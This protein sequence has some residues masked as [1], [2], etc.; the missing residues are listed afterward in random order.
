MSR[1]AGGDL[2]GGIAWG[3]AGFAASLVLGVVLEPFRD[4][5]VGEHVV[6]AFLAVVIVTAAAGGRAAGVLSALSAALAYN[7]FFTTPYRTL[8]IDSAEQVVT[9][10]LL[11]AA[12]LL[13]SAGG[14]VARRA[15]RNERLAAGALDLL[16]EV[17][18]AV[19]D[20]PGPGA[21]RVAA[22]GVRA[23]LG[24]RRVEV[25]RGEEVTASA[26]EAGER[27]DEDRLPRMEP[28][29]RLPDVR[30]FRTAGLVLPARGLAVPLV[31]GERPVGAMLVVPGDDRG[32]PRSVREALATVGHVLA[33]APAPRPAGPT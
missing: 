6:I 22:E 15:E 3:G 27:L 12:G 19:A 29:G 25:R 9:V 28:D 14:R 10:V 2:G 13:A 17:A 32:V 7:F 30:R 20:R 16:N 26:G 31:R 5:L 23:L 8:R 33:A 11:F 1:R 4:R 18:M 24:A 21:D